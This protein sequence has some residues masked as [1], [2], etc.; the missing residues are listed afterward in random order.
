MRYIMH[1]YTDEKCRVIL[2]NIVAAME[3]Y[4]ILL[5]DEV[6]IPDTGAH[7]Y[8][9]DKDIAMMVNHAGMERTL[10]QWLTLLSSVGLN[11][12]KLGTYNETSGESVLVAKLVEGRKA[13]VNL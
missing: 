13:E 6:V 2:R 12:V 11:I 4:S 8:S 9:T 7:P 1:D 5:I 10:D 3:P